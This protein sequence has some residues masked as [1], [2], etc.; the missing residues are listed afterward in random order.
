MASKTFEVPIQAPDAWRFDDVEAASVLP[1]RKANATALKALFS[2]TELRELARRRA[3]IGP[4]TVAF[5][6][7]ENPW[8][9]S[10][11]IAAVA[12][13]LPRE[14]AAAGEQV[15]R[16]SPLHS[17]LKG[18]VLSMT[19]ALAV[20]LGQHGITVNAVAPG[21]VMTD[22]LIAAVPETA[23]QQR[24]ASDAP[25]G[26]IGRVE[27]IAGAVLFL[28]SDEADWMTG[29]ILSVDGGLSILK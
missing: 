1:R 5:L 13:M 23:G 16:I 14:L 20:D 4:R 28:A 12:R 26:R 11:G 18:A 21:P 15:V 19:R 8:G 3:A 25:L 27:D 22:M 10:G 7:Y 17:S 29:Q 2:E 6:S 24:L 9:T